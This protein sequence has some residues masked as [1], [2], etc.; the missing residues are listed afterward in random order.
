MQVL[1]GEEG[2]ALGQGA[3]ASTTRALK[4]RGALHTATPGEHGA[5]RPR[6]GGR[7]HS[8]EWALR[9]SGPEGL[10][11]ASGHLG[12][13]SNGD[14]QNTRLHVAQGRVASGVPSDNESGHRLT[15]GGAGLSCPS[16]GQRRREASGPRTSGSSWVVA[17]GPA[18][19][20]GCLGPAPGS[21]TIQPSTIQPARCPR[22]LGRLRHAP[23][24]ALS[25]PSSGAAPPRPQGSGSRIPQHSPPDP[26]PWLW[27]QQFWFPTA[28]HCGACVLDPPQPEQ[29]Y[30]PLTP[31]P[32]A[33]TR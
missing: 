26:D 33:E 17:P 11:P 19:S 21:A 30:G 13:S 5:H 32:R 15:H 2:A 25:S 6:T 20:P 4:P 12:Q 22:G 7:L 14:P 24:A 28:A 1:P 31:D 16:D 23:L 9:P 10:P 8:G 27:R 3:W 18:S 29:L